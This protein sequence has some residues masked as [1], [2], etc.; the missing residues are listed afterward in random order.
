MSADNGIY[1]VQFKDGWRVAHLQGIDSIYWHPTCCDNPDV[2]ETY[3]CNLA[4]ANSIE[5]IYYHEQC[6][7][8]CTIDP[9]WE[10]REDINLDTI[11]QMFKQSYL[12]ETEEDAM[13]QADILYSEI[14]GNDFGGIVE[15][16]IQKINGLE[17][18]DFPT[19][20]TI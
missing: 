16:G 9:E 17:N 10:R 6:S 4:E 1:L 7:N 14:L 13:I 2:H 15:Y 19:K 3:A 11:A 12:F 8:C 5:D 20:G 18:F